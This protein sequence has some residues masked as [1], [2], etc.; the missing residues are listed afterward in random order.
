[1]A[2]VGDQRKPHHSAPSAPSAEGSELFL[3]LFN[4]FLESAK[5]SF[6]WLKPAA[7][8]DPV[9][10]PEISEDWEVIDLPSAGTRP[11]PTEAHGISQ[12]HAYRFPLRRWYPT[13]L[14]VFLPGLGQCESTNL[15]RNPHS[16][17]GPDQLWN[18]DQLL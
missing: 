3:R 5:D 7:Q 18:R 9:P 4:T 2:E 13:R 16:S 6:Q 10:V 11:S 1:M 17:G 8:P 12:P 14:G 15:Q